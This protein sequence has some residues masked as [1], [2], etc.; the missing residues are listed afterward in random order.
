MGLETSGGSVSQKISAKSINITTLPG[1]VAVQ[2]DLDHQWFNEKTIVLPDAVQAML[3]RRE[4]P[5]YLLREA[6]IISS[7]VPDIEVGQTWLVHP[8]EGQ[9]WS[10]QEVKETFGWDI[11]ESHQIRF[12]GVHANIYDQVLLRY[13]KGTKEETS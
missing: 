8:N 13:D 5:P 6:T 3:D 2:L 1:R 9:W 11:P 4:I 10:S 12:Y 7:G